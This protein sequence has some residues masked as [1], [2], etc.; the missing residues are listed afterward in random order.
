MSRTNT[1]FAEMLAGEYKNSFGEYPN[2]DTFYNEPDSYTIFKKINLEKLVFGKC[3]GQINEQIISPMLAAYIT[4][5]NKELVKLVDS[6]IRAEKIYHPAFFTG[7]YIN[8]IT[9]GRFGIKPGKGVRYA[10]PSEMRNDDV[11]LKNVIFKLFFRSI[12]QIEKFYTPLIHI[13][14]R[15][16]QPELEKVYETSPVPMLPPAPAEDEYDFNKNEKVFEGEFEDIAEEPSAVNRSEQSLEIVAE[17]L[18]CFN[19]DSEAWDDPQSLLE[20]IHSRLRTEI[21][22]YQDS[23]F[24]HE[25]IAFVSTAI[26]LCPEFED[27]F[28]KQ[29][30]LNEN[31]ES[32]E[33]MKQA[34]F[35]YGGDM[36]ILSG[37][38]GLKR[39]ALRHF[40]LNQ[41]SNSKE[42]ETNETFTFPEGF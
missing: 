33:W 41:D 24:L 2:Y 10:V 15:E 6:A 21:P 16:C 22:Y 17:L 35:E 26:L 30:K 3:Q 14:P 13:E 19:E 39:I 29:M 5:E 36:M 11:F 37:L 25:K 20:A 28:E 8:V 31:E 1:F 27:E 42:T 4:G 7:R 32:A 18:S 23:N 9:L 12:T 40:L 34:N 38:D